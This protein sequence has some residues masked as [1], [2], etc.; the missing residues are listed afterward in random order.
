MPVAGGFLLR[1]ES[2]NGTLVNG[3]RIVGTY[4]LANGD[5]VRVQDEELRVELDAFWSQA[6][7]NFK[8][9]AE[10]ENDKESRICND[11]HTADDCGH[12]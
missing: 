6:L 4:L 11:N 12:N 2:A 3:I 9:I 5:V 10:E 7:A 1:D 8:I